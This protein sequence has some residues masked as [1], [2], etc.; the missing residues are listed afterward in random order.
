[1]SLKNS[2]LGLW[3][4]ISVFTPSNVLAFTKFFSPAAITTKGRSEEKKT[5][6]IDFDFEAMPS[7]G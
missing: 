7:F 4:K 3:P 6:P 2:L 1:M 5:M